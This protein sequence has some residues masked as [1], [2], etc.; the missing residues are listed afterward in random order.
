[1]SCPLVNVEEAG[2]E[3]VKS[4]KPVDLRPRAVPSPPIMS[5]LSLSL[6]ELLLLESAGKAMLPAAVAETAA[7]AA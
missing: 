4:V 2:R 6:E 3:S 5:E 7:E 1:M